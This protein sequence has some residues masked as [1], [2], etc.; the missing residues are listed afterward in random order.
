MEGTDDSARPVLRGVSHQL[1]FW[2]A[3]VA[4]A[5]LVAHA[6]PG[7]PSGCALIFGASLV[8]LFAASALYH[9][10][11]WRPRARRW[12]RRLDHSAIFLAIAG[13]HTPLFALVP[14]TK[15]GHGA[16]AVTWIGAAMGVVKSLAWPDAPTWLTALFCALL[17]WVGATEVLDRVAVIG[18]APIGPFVAS[19]VTYT[20]GAV[21]LA[22]KRPNPVPRVFGYH[23][24]FHALVVLG[25][26]LLF[27]HVALV[28]GRS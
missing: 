9:R 2:P 1:A 12:M 27:G 3:L 18:A 26:V 28:L 22:T 23:E 7:L 20:L 19:G 6:R 4:T 11:D 21:V 15:G 17:G 10:V 8:V 25:T 16:L 24:V 13:G 14:S 5:A